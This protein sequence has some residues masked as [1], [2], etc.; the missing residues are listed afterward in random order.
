MSPP[1]FWRFA[2]HLPCFQPLYLL[3]IS[4]CCPGAESQSGCV[5]YVESPENQQFLLL[6][7]TLLVFTARSYGDLSSW[8]W[9]PG[10][11]CAVW[12]GAGI[13]H[14]PGSPPNFYP[15][16]VNVGLPIP[17]PPLLHATL[18]LRA[19]PSISTSPPLLHIWMN[20]ASLK[21]WLSD[22]HTT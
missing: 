5:L 16:H 9:N 10:L 15:L 8:Y 6:H 17:L 13:A 21:P 14:S 7:Q 1:G 11:D 3:P 19:S 20:V 22:F 4:S 12:P 2:R 18:S